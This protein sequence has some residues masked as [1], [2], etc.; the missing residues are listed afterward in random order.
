M[1]HYV[2]TCVVAMEPA[3]DLVLACVILHLQV[4]IAQNVYYISLIFILGLCPYGHPY[5]D[6]LVKNDQTEE[7]EHSYLECSGQGECDRTTGICGCYPG[8]TGD[9]CQRERCPNDCS[10]H[11]VCTAVKFMT[12]HN[13]IYEEVDDPGNYNFWDG[14]QSHICKCD[15]EYTGYDCSE[16]KCAIGYMSLSDCDTPL[17]GNTQTITVE[18]KN[19]DKN[20]IEFG[21]NKVQGL[22]G[23]LQ[24]TD[25]FGRVWF[26]DAFNFLKTN[27]EKD[28]ILGEYNKD[29][30]ECEVT[31]SNPI[32]NGVSYTLKG[33]WTTL[34]SFPPG[35]INVEK[36]EIYNDNTLKDCVSSTDSSRNDCKETPADIDKTQTYIIRI[37]YG[38]HQTGSYNDNIK[39]LTPK[40]VSIRQSSFDGGYHGLKTDPIQCLYKSDN[41]EYKVEDSTTYTITDQQ[42]STTI[43]PPPTKCAGN[44]ICDTVTGLCECFSGYYGLACTEQAELL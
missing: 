9:A 21:D 27:D 24:Y 19:E 34:N 25:S 17:D 30:K 29:G 14:V 1:Q 15:D 22:M 18:V 10:G 11:G 7:P 6:P 41:S 8:Y 3:Q 38:P 2:Q 35:T 43:I 23:Y 20:N 44:G 26:S 40:E 5:V 4:V 28:L 12:Y 13:G 33:W 32:K 37:T 36:V 39:I 16:K 42:I 31:D